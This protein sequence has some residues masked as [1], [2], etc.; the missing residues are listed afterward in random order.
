MELNFNKI[1][2]LVEIFE[3]LKD[4]ELPFKL[5]LIIAKNKNV[6]DKEVEFYVEQERAFAQKY[7]QIGED[8]QFIQD[9]PGVFKII[10]GKEE[11]CRIARQELDAFTADVDLRMIPMSLLEKMEQTFTPKQL[12]ALE[13][14]IDEEA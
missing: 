6:L 3:E 9:S 8:G 2:S 13:V 12:S 11:E 4:K 14:I 5:S 1:N 10:E 7:L